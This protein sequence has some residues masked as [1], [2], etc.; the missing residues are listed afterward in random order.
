MTDPILL[1]GAV[2]V[3]ASLPVT[4]WAVGG[5]RGNANEASHHLR[6]KTS[7][8]LHELLL[9]RSADERVVGPVVRGLS[10]RVRRFTPK[11]MISTLERRMALAGVPPSW[12]IERVLAAKLLMGFFA[13]LM[14]LV[15]LSGGL[16]KMNIGLAVVVLVVGYQFPD[17]L[18]NRRAQHRQD[19]IRR[20]LADAIDQVTISVEAGL[21]FDAAIARYSD[22]GTGP[23]ADEFARLLQDVQ[24]RSEERR[25]GKECRSRWSPYH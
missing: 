15:V 17:M 21:G 18:L 13:I 7:V 19:E 4:W 24:L 8:D 14:A 16:T 5:G 22:T 9:T 10:N 6:S 23:L 2:L 20:T 12:P 25:V 11:G 1:F 3:A